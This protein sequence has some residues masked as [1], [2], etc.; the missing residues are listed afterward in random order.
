MRQGVPTAIILV[1]F[2][3]LAIVI[4]AFV[5]KDADPRCWFSDDPVLCAV[6]SDK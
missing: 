3:V 4:Y 2:I 6:V 5:L 1:V